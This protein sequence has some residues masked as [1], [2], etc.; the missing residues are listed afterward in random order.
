MEFCLF[1]QEAQ[2]KK[3]KKKWLV[4]TFQC[5]PG[6]CVDFLKQSSRHHQQSNDG[7]PWLLHRNHL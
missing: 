2:I 6:C 3:I 1:L 5:I 4:E 7:N